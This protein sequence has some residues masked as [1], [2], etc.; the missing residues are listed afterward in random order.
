MKK[1]N[2]LKNNYDFTRII[3]N[4]KPFKYKYFVIYCERCEQSNY[5]FGL[6]VGKKIG[7]A[8]TRNKYKRV[9]RSI[10]SQMDYQKNFNCII[11]LSKD[12]LNYKYIDIKNDLT[13][14]FNK[15]NILKKENE[16]EK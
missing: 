4:N 16:N 12:V 9:L 1:I 13:Y 8:V 6:S 5:H 2:V 14:I 11:I 3:K 15:I 10:I 7:N